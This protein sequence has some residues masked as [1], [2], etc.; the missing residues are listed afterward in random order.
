MFLI[1]I[2][3]PRGDIEYETVMGLSFGAKYLTYVN[4]ILFRI[5]TLLLLYMYLVCIVLKIKTLL[6][7][8]ITIDFTMGFNDCIKF[9]G[10]LS[11]I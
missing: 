11:V 5:C 4:Y 1:T 3:F 8:F 10:Y 9:I 6:I 7:N 2:L